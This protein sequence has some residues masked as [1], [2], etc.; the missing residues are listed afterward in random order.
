MTVPD[1]W[2]PA[3]PEAGAGARAGAE[4]GA[5]AGAGHAPREWARHWRHAQLPGLDLLRA[6][7]VRHSFP[8]HSHDGYVVCA[9]TSGVEEVGLPHGVV[10]AGHGSVIMINPEVPHT[11]RAGVPEGWTYSTLYP[12][13]QLVADVAAE[14]STLRGTA[15]FTETTA[16]DPGAAHLVNAVHRAAEEGDALAADSV[17]RIV[18]ARLLRRHGG[19]L[20]ART[21]RTAGARTAARAKA[22]LEERMA[23]PP[24][25]EGLAHELR[26]SPFALLRAF[27]ETYGMPPHTWLTDA[28]VRRAR[29]LLEAG[30]MP[31][32]AAVAVGFTDQ[33]HLN[34]HFTRIVGVPPGA[35]RRE[36]A[37]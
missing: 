37:R 10:Q 25:L 12:S 11:A 18:L 23:D 31:A 13:A 22:L 27:K 14:T 33:P 5:G 36:R 30:T 9:V 24:G 15:G 29:H 7:Y 21:P 6:H 16:D 4:A 20:P 8:R 35:Y 2:L 26:T 34:R 19:P 3:G 17:L 32:E 28:R 1:T